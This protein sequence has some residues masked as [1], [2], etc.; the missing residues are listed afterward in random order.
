MCQK[1]Q[2][3][4][5]ASCKIARVFVSWIYAVFVRFALLVATILLQSAF[6]ATRTLECSKLNIGLIA[7]NGFRIRNSHTSDR[8]S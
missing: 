6:F 3:N 7:F 1:I 2:P 4:S 8:S 5:F